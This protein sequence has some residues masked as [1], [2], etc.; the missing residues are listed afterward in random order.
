MSSPE[1]EQSRCLDAPTYVAYKCSG[2][3]YHEARLNL[4]RAIAHPRNRYHWLLAKIDRER[5]LSPMDEMAIKEESV[6]HA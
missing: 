5:L 2:S 3:S 1:W 6:K 4:L